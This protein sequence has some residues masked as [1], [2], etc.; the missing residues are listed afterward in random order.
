MNIPHQQRGITMPGWIFLILIVGSTVTV[1]TKLAPLYLDHNTMG[2]IIDRLAQERGMVKK[3]NG[4]L[5]A[6]I[7]KR[8]KLNNIRTFDLKRN[9]TIKRPENRVVITLDYEVRV[10]LISNVDLVASFDKQTILR[11]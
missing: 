10:P 1:G 5:T 7:R 6:I 3:G 4:E 8:F 11:D 9:M 2:N